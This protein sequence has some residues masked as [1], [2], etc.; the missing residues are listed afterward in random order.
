M[1]VILILG[2]P[3]VLELGVGTQTLLLDAL[4]W[5]R[6]LDNLLT[7]MSRSLNSFCNM[8][9]SKFVGDDRSVILEFS[10]SPSN[11]LLAL[12]KLMR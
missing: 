3:K 4:I 5:R 12:Y 1:A 10:R 9:E 11:S 6:I 7:S 2:I 8:A